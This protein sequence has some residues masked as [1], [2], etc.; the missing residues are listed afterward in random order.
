MRIFGCLVLAFTLT[1]NAHALEASAGADNV[2]TSQ[3]GINA[4]IEASNAIT[5]VAISKM[6]SCAKLHALYDPNTN[7]C[8][9]VLTSETDPV[10]SPNISKVFNCGNANKIA[11]SDG[12]CSSVLPP[13]VSNQVT[14]IVSCNAQGKL[15]NGSGCADLPSGSKSKLVAVGG[16]IVQTPNQ[17]ASVATSMNADLCVLSNDGRYGKGR[18]NCSVNG[19]PGGSWTVTATSQDGTNIQCSMSCYNLQ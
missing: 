2:N 8:A 17:N 1:G 7:V 9:T 15:F 12:S 3:V 19:T 10:A 11:H 13:D 14:N 6:T 16:K 5:S 18:G 4:K